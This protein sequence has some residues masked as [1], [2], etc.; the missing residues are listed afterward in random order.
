MLVETDFYLR[1]NELKN[2]VYC[3]RTTFYELCLHLN[4]TTASAEMGQEAER[5]VKEKLRRRKQALHTVVE[6]ERR[7]DVTVFSHKHRLVGKID[8]LVLAADGIHIV[9]YKDTPTDYGYWKMQLMG[10]RLCVEESYERPVVGCWVYIIPEKRYQP[11]TLSKRDMKKLEDT[12][13]FI[14]QMIEAER[15]P[16]P[17]KQRGKCYSCQYRRFCNDIE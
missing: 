3:P 12:R 10:Y 13:Q 2:F 17:V 7:F 16:P 14:L 9:E 15:C 6:G 11:I 5:E 4:L 8:E 1:I